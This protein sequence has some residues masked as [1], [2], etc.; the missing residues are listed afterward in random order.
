MKVTLHKTSEFGVKYYCDQHPTRE[1]SS[2]LKT[3][4]W[5]GSKFDLTGIEIHLCDACMEELYKILKK[6]FNINPIDIINI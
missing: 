5:Y 3:A 2:E 4:S 1:C 6:Q